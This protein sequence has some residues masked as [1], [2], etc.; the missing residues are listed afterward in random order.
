MQ[1]CPLIESTCIAQILK[2]CRFLKVL[3]L[4]GAKKLND[5]AF[6]E[7]YETQVKHADNRDLSIRPLNA[8][9]SLEILNLASCDYVT[10]ALLLK[11][12][13]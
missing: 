2:N 1:W 10:D 11:I 5:A 9:D 6:I 3:D 8:L 4:A 7:A 12:K 13:V